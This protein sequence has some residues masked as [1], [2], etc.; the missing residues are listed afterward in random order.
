MHAV[1]TGA[2]YQVLSYFYLSP[3]SDH[4]NY[5]TGFSPHTVNRT[6]C[7]SKPFLHP[8]PRLNNSSFYYPTQLGQQEVLTHPRGLIRHRP[9]HD[10]RTRR[11]RGRWLHGQPRSVQL[12]SSTPI[13]NDQT[14]DKVG[15][16]YFLSTKGES[17]QSTTVKSSAQPK[18]YVACPSTGSADN[19]G[20]YSCNSG[21][22]I[23]AAKK[24]STTEVLLTAGATP[25]RSADMLM[26]AALGFV[27]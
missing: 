3:W 25:L 27:F 6:C 12:Q 13:P 20:R 22:D 4:V 14:C 21:L 8:S 26:V 16:C 7:V 15:D 17:A 9:C 5:S 1:H 18:P 2:Y 19:Q 24:N 10:R 23:K 11:M